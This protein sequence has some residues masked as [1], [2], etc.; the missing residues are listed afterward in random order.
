MNFFYR[1]QLFAAFFVFALCAIGTGAWAEEQSSATYEALK[2]EVWKSIKPD[3]FGDRA[4]I[5]DDQVIALDAP[6]K[7]EDAAVTPVGVNALFPQAPEK[8]IKAIT[9]IVDENPAPVVATFTFGPAAS[10]ASLSTRVRV[11]AFSYIRAIAELNDGSLHMVKK[12]VKAAGGCSAPAS[13]DPDKA[14]AELGKMKLRQFPLKGEDANSPQ[15]SREAQIMIRH[16]NN[17][18]LQRDQ[19]TLLAIPAFFV[20]YLEIKRGDELVFQMEGGISISEDPNIRFHFKG[21]AGAEI[22]AKAVDTKEHTFEQS[23]PVEAEGS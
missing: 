22:H 23:W 2:E 3:I 18:G 6:P 9:L 11:N 10:Q 20:R 17:S 14:L 1:S 7:A 4:I 13:K 12:F 8:F 19:V 15:A 16:P 21:P 5:E